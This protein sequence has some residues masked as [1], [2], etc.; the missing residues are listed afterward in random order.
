[1]GEATPVI[2]RC[3]DVCATD[4]LGDRRERDV[5]VG[6]GVGLIGSVMGSW[7]RYVAQS[8]VAQLFVT[9][10]VVTDYE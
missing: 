9:K 8:S 2:M 10:H 4:H 5:R 6:L 3:T 7:L 1:M